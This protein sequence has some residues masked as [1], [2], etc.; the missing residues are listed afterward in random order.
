MDLLLGDAFIVLHCC[1]AFLFVSI[2]LMRCCD[3]VDVIVVH[4]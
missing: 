2:L 1:C 4:Y 3:I